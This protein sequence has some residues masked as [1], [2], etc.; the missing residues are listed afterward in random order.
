MLSP[1]QHGL[2]QH[3]QLSHRLST[4]SLYRQLAT[5]SGSQSISPE[6]TRSLSGKSTSHVHPDTIASGSEH[7]HDL[8]SFLA[9]ASDTKLDTTST[10]F[11]GVHYEYTVAQ[12]LQRFGFNLT[13]TGRADDKGIDLLGRWALPSQ[14]QQQILRVIIQC[15]AAKPTPDTV[16]AVQG[17]L[18][19]AP[20]AWKR[21][22]TLLLLAATAE[23]TKGVREAI[24]RSSRLMGYLNISADGY[25]RQFLW[26]QRAAQGCLH[27]LGATVRH[28]GAATTNTVQE[29]VLT[30]NNEALT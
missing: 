18:D 28:G 2:R 11:Q 8:T 21:E 4:L 1:A 7:H 30:W 15:K 17:S 27:G 19:G 26:N 24:S 3:V 23:A 13:R 22:E 6:S 10:V 29:L 9:Y 12:T 25:L 16:R 20:F 5:S 14:A